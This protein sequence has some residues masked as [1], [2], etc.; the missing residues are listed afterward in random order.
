VANPVADRKTRDD[1]HVVSDVMHKKFQ[2]KMSEDEQEL[3][4]NYFYA[5]RKGLGKD[6]E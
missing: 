2:M 3:L 5:I 1:W 4:I 6:P